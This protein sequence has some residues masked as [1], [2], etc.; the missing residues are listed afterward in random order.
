MHRRVPDISKV[1]AAVGHRPSHS[2]DQILESV[3]ASIRDPR[4]GGKSSPEAR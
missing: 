3:I 2:L 1:A 4:A